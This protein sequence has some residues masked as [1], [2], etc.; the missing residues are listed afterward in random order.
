MFDIT[1]RAAL[2]TGA[3]QGMGL[4]I[5]KALVAAGAKVYINDIH[6]D[7]AIAASAGI[8]NAFALP[9][10]ITDPAIRQRMA[11]TIG[12]LDILCNN[13]GVP[14]DM[15]N[16]FKQ[17]PD[18]EEH[19]YKKQMDLNF[20]A[21]RGLCNLFVPGMKARG[22][23][24]ILIISSEAHRLGVAHGL[25]HYSAAKA[26][27]MGYMRALAAETG[28]S[29]ITVN[30]LSLGAMNNFE[31]SDRAAASTIIGRAGTPEDVGAAALYL[32][33]D[34]ASWMTGQTI[35]LNGGAS[36]A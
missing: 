29:G 1:G 2:V 31:G 24:R 10:D 11:A 28:R 25:S 14:T 30:G 8:A 12:D 32:C 6:K 15:Q 7:R 19:H 16:S 26:A 4:G 18:L 27:A 9:G 21:V 35:A 34:E 20:H 22:H 3:G 17:V 36:T 33:S 23:G 13:A 5:A